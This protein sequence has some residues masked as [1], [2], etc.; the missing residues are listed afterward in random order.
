MGRWVSKQREIFW[1]KKKDPSA[2]V[3]KSARLDEDRIARLE[4]IGFLWVGANAS[5]QA[6]E[7]KDIGRGS[8]TNDNHTSV[9]ATS[10]VEDENTIAKGL[11]HI[12][13]NY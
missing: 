7:G 10:I 4:A 6:R 3:Y 2:R 13:Q 11:E 5:R 9:E 1:D 8:A 12:L